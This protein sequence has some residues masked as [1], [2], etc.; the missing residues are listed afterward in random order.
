MCHCG[1]SRPR[2]PSPT[3][4]SG[5]PARTPLASCGGTSAS[6]IQI[7]DEIGLPI[8]GA[9]VQLTIG[10]VT[11]TTTSDGNGIVCFTQP[12]GTS[13]RVQL[14]DMHEAS[15]GESTRTPSGRHFR[16]NGPGP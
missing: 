3:P 16:T 13:V 15:A 9:S 4:R 2:R 10:G 14:V 12:P 6:A 11:S 5:A 1:T 7:I 8:G